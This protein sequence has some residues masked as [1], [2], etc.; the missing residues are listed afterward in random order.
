MLLLIRVL[1]VISRIVQARLATVLKMSW[2][3]LIPQSSFSAASFLSTLHFYL[4]PW[5]GG[6][7]QAY[8]FK[9]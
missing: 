9:S 2:Y 3:C 7:A 5:A 6:R 1:L 4:N 8:Y